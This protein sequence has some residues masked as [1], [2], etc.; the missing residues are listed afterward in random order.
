MSTPARRTFQRD[1]VIWLDKNVTTS[2]DCAKARHDLQ[3]ITNSVKTFSNPNTCVDFLLRMNSNDE[4]VFFIVS[5][6]LGE[7][8]IQLI[9]PMQH[10]H[11]IYVYSSN[12]S[13]I[14]SW[15]N[16]YDKV[17]P[18]VF[19]NVTSI[20][21]QLKNDRKKYENDF[22]AISFVSKSEI[23]AENRQ[24][25]SFMYNQLLK[26]ILKDNKNDAEEVARKQM[27]DFCREYYKNNDCELKI[28]EEFER[29]FFPE[30]AFY[31]YTRDC[32]L[33]KILNK[34]LWTPEPAILYKLRYFIRHL[35]QQLTITASQQLQRQHV[36]KV[37]RGQGIP[38]CEFNKLRNGVGGLL[39]FNNFLST[40]LNRNIARD[41][42]EPAKYLSDETSVIFS[43]N[44]DS[45]KSKCSFIV[46][47]N[48]GFYQ[49]LEQEVLF[50]MGTVF[51]IENVKKTS[52]DQ[53]EVQLTLTDNTVDNLAHYTAKVRK[54]IHS[55]HI[56]ISLVKLMDEMGQYK[57]IDVFADVFA[58]DNIIH[59]HPGRLAEMQHAMGSA[60]LS[61]GNKNKALEFLENA[62]ATYLTLVPADYPSLS[63][64]YNNIGSVYLSK[65]NHKKAL[66]YQQKA[67]DCQLNASDPNL[68]S[69]AT[70]SMNIA[71]IHES[72]GQ[73][74]EA[75]V[76]LQRALELQ[77]QYLGEDDPA[78][79]LTYDVIARICYEKQ[80]FERAGMSRLEMR[81]LF[82]WIVFVF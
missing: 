65:K 39:S 32:F 74:D 25:P 33:Y 38:T 19:E 20:C 61:A 6:T 48:L 47:G 21:E 49:N 73:H 24:D 54:Q 77:K 43:M 57:M 71:T 64:T 44:I 81:T 51:L 40:S 34:A 10:V 26:D 72:L 46:V 15:T 78:L 79:S 56:L 16:Q 53:W 27:L 29:E 5:D 17:S 42:A 11:R 52:T 55:S 7:G 82:P 50:S 28:I 69:I 70:Y 75:L 30:H 60:Y 1:S 35:D 13:N 23:D 58:E 62:L 36:K 59:Q 41:F 37:F 8:I 12:T 14:V 45:H 18:N 3:A 9:H 2:K 68:N 31:W 76:H 4:L 67:L 22:V 80:E 63:P 66:E